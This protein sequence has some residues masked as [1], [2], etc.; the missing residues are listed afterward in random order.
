[1]LGNRGPLSRFLVT[2]TVSSLISCRLSTSADRRLKLSSFGL[3]I[4]S[5]E[6]GFFVLFFKEG[7]V[8]FFTLF[9]KFWLRSDADAGSSKSQVAKRRVFA[10]RQPREQSNGAKIQLSE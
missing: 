10:Q 9:G 1:M 7:V 2:F 5:I 6:E 4:T 3:A 8:P